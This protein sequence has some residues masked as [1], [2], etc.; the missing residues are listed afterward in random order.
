[1]LA[2][3][4][5]TFCTTGNMQTLETVPS[6]PRLDGEQDPEDEADSALNVIC[7][8]KYPPYN[9]DN[10]CLSLENK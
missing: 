10:S 3:R 5:A 6:I 9:E 1:M 4:V 8:W 7:P 2:T